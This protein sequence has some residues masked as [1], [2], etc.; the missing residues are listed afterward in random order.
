MNRKLPR[1]RGQWNYEA[2]FSLLKNSN[3]FA[4]STGEERWAMNG[5]FNSSFPFFAEGGQGEGGGSWQG[6]KIFWVGGPKPKCKDRK[7]KT[8]REKNYLPKL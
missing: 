5:Q 3:F 1:K 8:D 4:K 7:G 2:F 6:E